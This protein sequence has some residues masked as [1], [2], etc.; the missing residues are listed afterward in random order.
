MDFMA[1]SMALTTPDI[2]LVTFLVVTADC[3]L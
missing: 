1:E 3:T 2:E